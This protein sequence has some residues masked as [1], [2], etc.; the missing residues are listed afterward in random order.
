M[1]AGTTSATAGGA[2]GAGGAPTAATSGGAVGVPVV[3]PNVFAKPEAMVAV[4]YIFAN[5]SLTPITDATAKNRAIT[6]ASKT[7]TT[8]WLPQVANVAL[9]SM[10]TGVMNDEAKARTLGL[11]IHEMNFRPDTTGGAVAEGTLSHLVVF[12][13]ATHSTIVD[14]DLA[15]AD[16]TIDAAFASNFANLSMLSTWGGAVQRVC[17]ATPLVP[18][19]PGVM[20][21]PPTFPAPTTLSL[22]AN[23]AAALTEGANT[24]AKSQREIA[25]MDPAF[26]ADIRAHKRAD[27]ADVDRSTS[28]PDTISLLQTLTTNPATPV[29]DQEM[30]AGN[31][32]EK[33]LLRDTSSKP[34]EKLAQRAVMFGNIRGNDPTNDKHVSILQQLDLGCTVKL[35]FLINRATNHAQIDVIAMVERLRRCDSRLFYRNCDK[36]DCL[37]GCQ[38]GSQSAPSFKSIHDVAA[39]LTNIAPIFN[40]IGIDFTGAKA[41]IIITARLFVDDHGVQN[42]DTV[43]QQYVKFFF[44]K[45]VYCYGDPSNPANYL[46]NP[47]ATRPNMTTWALVRKLADIPTTLPER[48]QNALKDILVQ[49]TA[50]SQSGKGPDGASVVKVTKDMQRYGQQLSRL[51]DRMDGVEGQKR[52][53]MHSEAE[54]AGKRF[55]EPAESI[56]PG[57]FWPDDPVKFHPAVSKAMYKAY[58]DYFT[59]TNS[60]VRCIF[61]DLSLVPGYE[62]W[63]T[64]CQSRQNRGDGKKCGFKHVGEVVNGVP[65]PACD[66]Q[67]M[68]QLLAQY[69]GFP[70]TPPHR[71]MWPKGWNPKKS[72]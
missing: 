49:I 33:L 9:K 64:K 72:S 63:Q 36:V 27:P 37:L 50:V 7:L 23:A 57:H 70:K 52:G 24:N 38:R 31:L 47:G 53:A 60:N 29:A 68:T 4:A 3:L 66:V 22:D 65:T 16:V 51:T 42:F 6:L 10:W 59:P 43:F 12:D 15:N 39:L 48:E 45:F 40:T 19:G 35:T 14:A 32:C 58:K 28:D 30:E 21:P 41:E 17:G 44:Q 11:I 56:P 20:P 71:H 62:A 5:K 1:L 67:F 18:F 13:L 26:Q 34:M 2:G 69:P 55:S 61:S 54:P 8:A 25:A 46:R